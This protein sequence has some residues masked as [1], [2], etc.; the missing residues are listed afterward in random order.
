MP[1]RSLNEEKQFRSGVIKKV[2]GESFDT[3]RQKTFEQLLENTHG[4][5]ENYERNAKRLNESTQATDIGP[6]RYH[7]YD[8]ITGIFPN[9]VAHEVVSVQALQQKNG[10]VFYLRFVYGNDKGNVD[11]GGVALDPWTVDSQHSYTTETV[12]NE[13]LGILGEES[14]TGNLAWT[15]ARPGTVVIDAGAVTA[16][17]NGKGVISGDGV[18]GTIDYATGA[19]TLTFTADT[20]ADVL[21]SYE[22]NLEYAP[23]K[24]PELKAEVV[25]LPISAR[26]RRLRATYAFEASYDFEKQYGKSLDETLL[27]AS[28]S[29][30]RHEIDME[31]LNDL[32]VQA[33]FSISWN[34]AAP[35]G[36]SY[37]DHKDT[38]YDAIVK[39]SNLIYGRSKR[40]KGNVVIVG[41]NAQNII[42]TLPAF[43]GNGIKDVAGPTVIG[44][45]K[46]FTVIANPHYPEDTFVVAYKGK[47]NDLDAGYVYAPY[48]PV[49]STNLVMLDDFVGRRGYATS[50]GKR[51]INRYYY[52]TGTITHNPASNALGVE[53]LNTVDNPVNTKEV[54]TDDEA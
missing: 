41:T 19:Y 5:I 35:V 9:L 22:Y 32:R 54:A 47:T 29:E 37:R 26:P 45:L 30:I 34:D 6:F 16:T 39:A 46:N 24:A 25:Q 33:G 4:V 17:D 38:F 28:I 53:V 15:P 27:E 1:K 10:Q 44:Q 50:Y 21:V 18:T 31:I 51:M 2:F 23:T 13:V 42:E 3:H 20:E 8:L 48:L 43:T 7:A 36:V 52:V 14:Y 11:K 40:V 12:D 49:V